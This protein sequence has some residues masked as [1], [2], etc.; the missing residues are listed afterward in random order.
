MHTSGRLGE[1]KHALQIA[2]RD[3]GRYDRRGL[4]RRET[5]SSLG[6]LGSIRLN[7]RELTSSPTDGAGDHARSRAGLAARSREFSGPA[8]AGADIVS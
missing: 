7:Q 2:A 5:G 6:K 8:A 3:R 1:T 4:A